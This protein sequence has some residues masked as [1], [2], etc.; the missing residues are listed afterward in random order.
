MTSHAAVVARGMG[1]CCVS[2]C[3]ELLIKEDEKFFQTS[4]GKKYYE[5]AWISLDGTSGNVYSGKIATEEATLSGD[6][7]TIMDWAD[8]YRTMKIR[9]NADTVRDAKVAFDLGA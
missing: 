5:G 1:K 7:K 9:T 4:D 6:F 3:S 8:E 2:G